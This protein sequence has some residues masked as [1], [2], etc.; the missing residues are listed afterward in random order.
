MNLW[1]L[2][3]FISRVYIEVCQ[4]L[5]KDF[6]FIGDYNHATLQKRP[7]V[8]TFGST[9][10]EWL[11]TCNEILVNLTF[12][13][14]QRFQSL[15]LARYILTVFNLF[16]EL[17]KFHKLICYRDK[18][19]YFLFHCGNN[20]SFLTVIDFQFYLIVS[21]RWNPENSSCTIRR[22]HWMM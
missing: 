10:S 18:S 9:E 3:Y 1:T 8:L 19:S 21:S 6:V 2:F 7:V 11:N 12:W 4:R 5:V 20:L 15:W 17:I 13:Y 22:V 14:L 16:A